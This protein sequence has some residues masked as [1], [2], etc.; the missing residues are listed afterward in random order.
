MESMMEADATW[1]RIR[2]E[3]EMIASIYDPEI[4]RRYPGGRLA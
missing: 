4:F 1:K 2:R 3:G